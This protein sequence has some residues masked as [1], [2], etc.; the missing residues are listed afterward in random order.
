MRA[1]LRRCLR[2]G[3]GPPPPDCLAPLSTAT[4]LVLRGLLGAE[5]EWLDVARGALLGAGISV[6]FLSLADV[7]MGTCPAPP[8]GVLLFDHAAGW[9]NE[10]LFT[11]PATPLLFCHPAPPPAPLLREAALLTLKTQLNALLARCPPDDALAIA[12]Y[13]AALRGELPRNATGTLCPDPS[14]LASRL[15][16]AAHNC[17]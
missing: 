5:R 17:V 6:R 2:E 13:T 11:L 12:L 14:A 4:L 9:A 7:L 3:A 15:A 16:A 10:W 1:A 8:T